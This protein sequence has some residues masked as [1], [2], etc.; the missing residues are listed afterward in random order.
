MAREAESPRWLMIA[1]GM[2]SADADSMTTRPDGSL[3]EFG[4]LDTSRVRM[5]GKGHLKWVRIAEKLSVVK[6][7]LSIFVRLR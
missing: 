6:L 3:I 7:K 4:P 1:G 5:E 2:A